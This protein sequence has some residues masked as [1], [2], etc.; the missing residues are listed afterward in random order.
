MKILIDNGDPQFS[1]LGD[2]A[3]LLSAYFALK[4]EW[5]EAEVFT[6]AL[7]PE[8][9]REV[10][11]DA[12]PVNPYDRSRWSGVMALGWLAESYSP[13][14][15]S[16]ARLFRNFVSSRLIS[17]VIDLAPG[18]C[19][20]KQLE[21]AR[22]ARFLEEID[23]YVW[24]GGGYL[25]D[26]F[27]SLAA[28]FANTLEYLASKGVPSVAF[29]LGIGPLDRPRIAT[30]VKGSMQNLSFIGLRD[31]LSSQLLQQWLFPETN[32]CVTGDDAIPLVFP[33]RPSE[34]G[35]NLGISL[36]ATYYSGLSEIHFQSISQVLRVFCSKQDVGL[37]SI[38]IARQDLITIRPVG[39][40]E[41]RFTEP[42]FTIEAVL[43][44]V[45]SCRVV[46]AG[47]YHAAAF[48]LSMGVSIVA[49]AGTDYYRQ[50]FAGLK[51]QFGGLF[52]ILAFDSSTEPAMFTE[53]LAK[54]VDDAWR[55]APDRRAALIQKVEAQIDVGHAFRE[56]VFK[57]LRARLPR[58]LVKTDGSCDAT[59]P[60][61]AS[62]GESILQ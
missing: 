18:E 49:I 52:E 53:S 8:R 19:R 2:L 33:H 10:L 35:Q 61:P 43:E 15:K 24:A 50:K 23:L 25:A 3:L 27:G 28:Q 42:D 40:A 38:P 32:F 58:A 6:S 13:L 29:G 44:S 41:L 39:C 30:A 45:A 31:K 55:D 9:L 51:E 59:P 34:I 21:F 16:S 56:T 5:P 14:F 22:F 47:S 57:H 60:T 11:P 48:A 37:A 1:N 7:K 26:H 62:K 4:A 17:R 20:S 36:R 54:L 12:K 46:V